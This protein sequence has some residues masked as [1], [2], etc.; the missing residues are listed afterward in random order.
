[1]YLDYRSGHNF[2]DV[3]AGDTIGCGTEWEL[4]RV[5]FTFNGQRLGEF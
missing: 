3:H 4:N 2:P 5:F 1:M